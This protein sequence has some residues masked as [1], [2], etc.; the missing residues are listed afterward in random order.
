VLLSG[1]L[2][3]SPSNAM[4]PEPRSTSVA[5]GYPD[6]SSRFSTV[7]MGRKLG[8]AVP[9]WEEGELGLHLTQ[10]GLWTADRF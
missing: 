2:A 4:W 3:G 6:A 10:C 5:S 8:G 7:D 9:L 1:E